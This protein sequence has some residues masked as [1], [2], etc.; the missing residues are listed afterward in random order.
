MASFTGSRSISSL[1]AVGVTVFAVGL[2][3][4]LWPTASPSAIAQE[5]CTQPSAT[6]CPMPIGSLVQAV[7]N[8]PGAYIERGYK[9][10]FGPF[11][12]IWASDGRGLR[13]S[14]SGRFY[15]FLEPK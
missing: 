15:G 11:L 12:D 7:L 10:R 4:G 6:G 1:L 2:T 14:E 8:D 5:E 13:Y 9:Q 3:S